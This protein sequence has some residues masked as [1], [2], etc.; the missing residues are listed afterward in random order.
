MWAWSPVATICKWWKGPGVGDLQFHLSCSV[1]YVG[2]YCRSALFICWDHV[3]VFDLHNR[4][5]APLYID[6]LDARCAVCCGCC[7][8]LDFHPALSQCIW[9]RRLCSERLSK[10]NSVKR[11]SPDDHRSFL[12]LPIFTDTPSACLPQSS[13]T[14]AMGGLDLS[15]LETLALWK[16][17]RWSS[18]THTWDAHFIVAVYSREQVRN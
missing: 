4:D 13:S 10:N 11:S 16:G 6:T 2:R 18:K 3:C 12:L 8:F 1:L 14:L 7:C 5:R 9:E 15:L 17:K